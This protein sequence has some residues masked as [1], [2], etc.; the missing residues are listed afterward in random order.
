MPKKSDDDFTETIRMTEDEKWRL[1]CVALGNEMAEL[2]EI[3]IVALRENFKTGSPHP[4]ITIQMH[5]AEAGEMPKVKLK[6]SIPKLRGSDERDVD[7]NQPRWFQ[8]QRP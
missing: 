2:L 7:L 6:I 3:N 8:G 4:S 5:P 1:S